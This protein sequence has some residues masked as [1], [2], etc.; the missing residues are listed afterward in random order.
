MKLYFLIGG[1]WL[2]PASNLRA[3]IRYGFDPS[4]RNFSLGFRLV[5]SKP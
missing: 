5:R 4:A 2:S 3:S 1:S